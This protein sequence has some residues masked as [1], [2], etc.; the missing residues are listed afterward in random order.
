MKRKGE[1]KISVQGNPFSYN[2]KNQWNF[3][4]YKADD[5]SIDLGIKQILELIKRL[6]G[7]G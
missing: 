5:M 7:K 3:G 4:V 2:P 6:S 1:V